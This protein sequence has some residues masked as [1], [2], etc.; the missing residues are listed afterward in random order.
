MSHADDVH[1]S[2]RTMRSRGVDRLVARH[3]VPR[4][5]ALVRPGEIVV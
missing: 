5:A 1:L 4:I 3:A 2:R